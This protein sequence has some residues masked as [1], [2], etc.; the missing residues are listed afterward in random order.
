[1]I[2]E[3]DIEKHLIEDEKD[4]EL[5]AAEQPQLAAETRFREEINVAEVDMTSTF[6]SSELTSLDPDEIL[7]E[8]ARSLPGDP[9]NLESITQYL[10]SVDEYESGRRFQVEPVTPPE[11]IL[12]P[13]LQ[14][15][16]PHMESLQLNPASITEASEAST[17]FRDRI[18][19]N[20]L[21]AN[22]RSIRQLGKQRAVRSFEIG[23]AVSVAV[24]ALD[25][26]SID[27]KRVFGQI[28]RILSG[29]I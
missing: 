5:I 9:I 12:D 16:S 8:Y 1:M 24:P 15:L 13:E 28:I 27:D 17:L 29:L 18:H 26:A 14:S 6:A 2:T 19:D 21:H 10:N 11:L 20:Q 25:R 23:E 3:A 4:D 7:S 22:E